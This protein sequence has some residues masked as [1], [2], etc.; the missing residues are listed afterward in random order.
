[1]ARTYQRSEIR[2]RVEA[3]VDDESNVLL[4]EAQYNVLIDESYAWLWDKLIESG[5][6]PDVATH[7]IS[8]TSGT[9]YAL[10][11]R[12]YRVLM[13]HYQSDSN[14]WLKLRP[15]NIEDLTHFLNT[16]AQ[17]AT[18]YLLVGDDNVHLLPAPPS[19]QTY[20]V[21]YV[22]SPAKLTQDTDTIDGVN[23]WEMLI[24]YDVA[25]K[26]RIRD[27]IDAADL[28]RE[29]AVL[30]DRLEVAK[31]NKLAQPTEVPDHKRDFNIG[32]DPGGYR[33]YRGRRW[34]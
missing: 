23:G 31:F 30:L 34:W 33:P 19:G 29:R 7:D 10:A 17:Y 15:I 22:P 25:I 5:I 26:A 20:R 13:V 12:N 8:T 4:T 18:R 11:T 1:M 21:W 6:Y 9:E 2:D 16:D 3:L 24:V 14:T 28:V 32:D 27:R